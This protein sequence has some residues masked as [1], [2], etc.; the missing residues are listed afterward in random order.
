MDWSVILIATAKIV[1]IYGALLSSIPILTWA[2]RRGAAFIQDR[3]GPN[4]VGPFGLFQ[5]M[6][7]FVKFLWKEDPIPLNVNKLLYVMGPFLTLIPASLT[8]AAIPVAESA[9]IFGREIPLQIADLNV[10]I[11][12]ILSIGSLGIYGILFGGWASNNKFSLLGAMRSSSQMI[13]YEI[14]LALS[15]AGAVLVFGSFSLRE[16]VQMQDGTVLGFLPAW[17]ICLQPLGFLIFLVASFAETNRIPFDLPEAEAELVAG[18]HTEYGSM[19]FATFFMAE[20]MNMVTISALM[21][22]LFLGGWHLPWVSD[23]FLLDKLGSVNGLALVQALVFLA[24]VGFLVCFYIW[25]RW[26]LPRFRYDQL[27]R[28]AWSNLLPLSLFNLVATA[29]VMYLGSLS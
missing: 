13:S 17:G 27:M 22:V 18:Y 15:A 20:Y 23:A 28:L 12:Y 3:P 1:V 29:F 2:E 19:K 10:G 26:T 25:I 9:V 7:D 16:M 11:L 6:A 21:V 5:P 24:K 14:P 8:I 4:R